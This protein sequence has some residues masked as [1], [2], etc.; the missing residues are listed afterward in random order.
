MAATAMVVAEN[1][2]AT[3]RKRATEVTVTDETEAVVVVAV[4]AN[5]AEVDASV[6]GCE[7]MAGE[8]QGV[9]T[10]E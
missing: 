4:E 7:A 9:A 5:E 6:K 8:H 2:Y 10:A 1:A 3:A